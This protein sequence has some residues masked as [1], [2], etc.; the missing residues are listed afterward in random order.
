[1][2]MGGAAL[3]VSIAK[4]AMG[5]LMSKLVMPGLVPAIHVFT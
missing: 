4:G 5:G 3:T 1:M 2:R